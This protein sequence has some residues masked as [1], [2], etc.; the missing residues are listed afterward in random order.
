MDIYIYEYT[1]GVEEE[2]IHDAHYESF[3]TNRILHNKQ[4]NHENVHIWN[5]SSWFK[6]SHPI[7][8]LFFYILYRPSSIIDIP[9]T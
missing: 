3:H 5:D 2:L 9:S 4:A 1:N 6:K 8:H 7:A